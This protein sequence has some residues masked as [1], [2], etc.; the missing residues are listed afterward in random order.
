METNSQRAWKSLSRLPDVVTDE[1]ILSYRQA[2]EDIRATIAR[3]YS[4]YM[5]EGELT[6]AQLTQFMR[7][8]NIEREIVDIMRPYVA[9]STQT[10]Q[11][12]S[13][14]GIEGSFFKHAWAVEQ[15]A[16][17]RLGWG[18]LSDTAVRAAA[19]IGG[20]LAELEG[21]LSKSEIEQHRRI[22]ADAFDK[23]YPKD[24][25]RWISRAVRDGVIQG[26]SVQKLAKRIEKDGL[27][28]SFSSAE[29][30]ARTETLR[31]LGIGNQVAFEQAADEGVQVT[32]VWDATLDAATRPA[33][34]ALDGV[35]ADGDGL[36]YPAS[37]SGGVPGPRRSG[38]ASFDINC[39]CRT[40]G[41]VAGY[42][43]SVR[44]IRNE[45][46]QPYTTFKD[47]ATERGFSVN[48]YGQEYSF[49]ME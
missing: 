11:R 7:V 10:I 31:A 14:A 48:Q 47:W 29:R 33:H 49:L 34:A 39:R 4:T 9:Q 5:A 2:L 44:R 20:D 40:T 43:P 19:G 45:G 13:Q 21:I 28:K 27:A 6:K 26:D 3:L 24:T 16:G 35:E 38:V 46:L 42:S 36:W 22:L 1:L 17:V 12:A 32:Q 30:I 41:N 23:T 15:A 18:Q 8:S 37:I 25:Q